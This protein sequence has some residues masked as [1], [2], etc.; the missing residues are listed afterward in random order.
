M[1]RIGLPVQTKNFY[2]GPDRDTL[3]SLRRLAKTCTGKAYVNVPF[4]QVRFV[5]VDLETTGFEADNG[6]EVISLAAVVVKEGKVS[7]KSALNMLVDPF[8]PIPENISDLTGIRNNMVRG[9]P[10]VYQAIKEFLNLLGDGVV[11]GHALGFDLGFLNYKL[12]QYKAGKI[13][14]VIYDTRV[15]ARYLQPVLNDY[16]LDS[17]LKACNIKSVGRH[18]ALGDCLLTAELLLHQLTKLEERQ[19]HNLAQLYQCRDKGTCSF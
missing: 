6:D 9:C 10:T 8:R 19:I 3:V 15:V 11:A 14:S 2:P 16:S 4:H 13:Q 17:L 1:S 5:V 12:A 7:L 18:S